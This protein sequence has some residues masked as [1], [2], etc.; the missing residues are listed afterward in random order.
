MYGPNDCVHCATT[1]A[2]VCSLF[3]IGYMSREVPKSLLYTELL[4]TFMNMNK[5]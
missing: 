3:A 1:E 4:E 5:V 2:Q